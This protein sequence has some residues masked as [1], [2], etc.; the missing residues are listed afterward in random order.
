MDAQLLCAISEVSEE[1]ELEETEVSTWKR[2]KDWIAWFFAYAQ[3]VLQSVE[4]SLGQKIPTTPSVDSLSRKLAYYV[5][6]VVNSGQWVQHRS[7]MTHGM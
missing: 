6:L 3:A 2:V 5:R 4:V 1:G 7:A